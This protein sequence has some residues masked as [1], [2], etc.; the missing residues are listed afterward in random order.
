MSGKLDI[1][2]E[3]GATFSRVLTI[4]DSTSTAVDISNDTFRGQVRSSFK[5]GAVEASFSF[6]FVTDGTDGKVAFTISDEATSA[7]TFG[8]NFVYDIEWVKANGS[9][10]RILEG[11][12]DVTAEVTR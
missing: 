9:V 12:A 10:V 3:Q 4:T 2:I 11:T 7:M 6:A 5:S 1:V 8:R